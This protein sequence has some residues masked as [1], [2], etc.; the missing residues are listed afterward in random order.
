MT[1]HSQVWRDAPVLAPVR[2][3]WA[4]PRPLRWVRVDDLPDYVYFDHSIHVAKGIGCVSCHGHV[5]Q[6]P[7]MAK[8]ASLAMRWCL[9]CHEHP[10]REMR[11]AS[12]IFEMRS[13]S[14]PEIARESESL[15]GAHLDTARLKDCSVCHR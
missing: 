10:E 9:D 2:E 12:A 11:P 3:S 4:E 8:G 14:D 13:S 15:R 5:E 6:M 1:C 7:L